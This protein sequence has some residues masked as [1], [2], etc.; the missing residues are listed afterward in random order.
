MSTAASAAAT[1]TP[2]DRVTGSGL[3]YAL[4]AYLLWGFLPA[5]FVLLAP[6]GP[7][8]V[9]GW[10]ILFSLIFCALLLTARRHWAPLLAL[11]RD[12]RVLLSLGAAAAVIYVNWQVFIIASLGGQVLQASLGYFINPIV[13]VLFGVIVL[14]ERLRAAQWVAVGISVAAIVVI[15]VGYGAVP[16]I[17]LVLALSF[18][19]YGLIKKRVGSRVDA[20]GGLTIETAWLAP[21]AVVQLTVVGVT[22]GF[23]FGRH[24]VVHTVLVLLT[25][26]ATALPLLLFASAARRLPLVALGLTQYLAPVLQFVTGVVLL[27]EEIDT[28]RWIGFGLVWV[29]VIVLSVDA[30]LAARRGRRIRVAAGVTGL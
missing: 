1:A 11:V 8:E 20:V 10:R 16:W 19:S 24:G 4:A 30:L 15:A 18:G 7:F 26:V 5:Y 29:A 3:G 28:E 14:R 23:E 27:H 12:R 21:L 17:S 25:G 9:V 13:T 6:V 2:A 22:G